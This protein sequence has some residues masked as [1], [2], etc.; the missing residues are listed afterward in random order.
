MVY[1]TM[2]YGTGKQV[3]GKR[4]KAGRERSAAFRLCEIAISSIIAD[5]RSM[6][7]DSRQ[8]G[9]A[10]GEAPKTKAEEKKR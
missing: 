5:R 6:M 2:L 1:N 7:I 3:K 8:S 9:R 4:A 10:A